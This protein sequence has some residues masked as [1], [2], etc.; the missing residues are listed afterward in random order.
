MGKTL[1]P[2]IKKVLLLE[3]IHSDAADKFKQYGIE[4]ECL[5][6]T[7][8]EEELKQ[9]IKDVNI[10]GVR[11]KTKL[12][13]EVLDCAEN[14]YCIGSYTKNA[15]QTNYDYSMKLGV[16]VFNSPFAH[17]RSVAELILAEMIAL[18]RMTLDHTETLHNK[19][20]KKTATGCYEVRGK[21]LGI[22]G[23]G[24]VGSQ[25]SVMAE[26]FGMNVLF[27]DIRTVLAHGNAT[28]VSLEQLLSSSNFISL[29][30]ADID[31]NKNM[32]GEKEFKTMQKGTFF[33]NAS[34]GRLVDY[35]A[36]AEAIKSKHIA[37]C[38]VDAHVDEP[39]DNGEDN[40]ESPLRN[41]KNTILTPH[42]GGGTQEGQEDIANDVTEKIINYL[43]YGITVGAMNFPII[44]IERNEDSKIQR[45]AIIHQNVPGVMKNLNN[46][47]ENYNVEG[48][49][50]G[51]KS[52]TGYCVIDVSGEKS[53]NEI[54]DLIGKMDTVLTVRNLDE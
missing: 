54:I 28:S 3:G 15:R 13:K 31:E 33:L 22:I 16:P 37:G 30:A 32:I 51:V 50:L 48:Q 36:L 49:Y 39:L 10:I 18:S 7:L 2:K 20:W 1:P 6:E 53:V 25:L 52:T 44:D 42:I 26:S 24:H 4:V 41:L 27:Y 35:N 29:H 46:I 5:T 34:A 17:A 11:S 19:G 12:S 14:L 38:A 21:T 9:K 43:Q 45:L 40:F 23:Y 8:P 47:L